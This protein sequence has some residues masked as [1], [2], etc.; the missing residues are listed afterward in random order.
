M[1]EPVISKSQ[2]ISLEMKMRDALRGFKEYE[3][4]TLDRLIWAMDGE[5]SHERVI[6]HD[7]LI[8]NKL[9]RW[10]WHCPNPKHANP[11]YVRRSH[12]TP[13]KIIKPAKGKM[14]GTR[15]SWPAYEDQTDLKPRRSSTT[16]KTHDL[17]QKLKPRRGPMLPAQRHERTAEP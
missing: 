10:N 8:H 11:Q 3:Y 14:F 17:L 16:A 13:P 15:T 9:L 7:E 1:S 5:L 6:E 12:P 2:L 4:F